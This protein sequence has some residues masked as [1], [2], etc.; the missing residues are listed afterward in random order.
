MSAV[1]RLAFAGLLRVPGPGGHISP[2][3]DTRIGLKRMGFNYNLIARLYFSF[4]VVLKN[5]VF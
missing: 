1:G 2:P 3:R 4:I 5:F